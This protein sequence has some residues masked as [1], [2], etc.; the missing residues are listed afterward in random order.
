MK[1]ESDLKP[2]L[3]HNVKWPIFDHLMHFI[4]SLTASVVY[5]FHLLSA[6]SDLYYLGLNAIEFFDSEGRKIELDENSEYLVPK[7]TDILCNVK[8]L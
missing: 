6:Q 3:L 4:P 2:F 1:L 7:H 8:A 5:Q